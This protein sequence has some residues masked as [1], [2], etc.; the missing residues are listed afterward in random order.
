MSLIKHI[1]LAVVVLTF[2][3]LAWAQNDVPYDTAKDE[4][5]R[6][7]IGIFEEPVR[8]KAR[9]G[10]I[11]SGASWGHSGPCVADVD[12]DG[13]RDLVVG[14]FSGLFR[15]FRNDGSN[16]QPSYVASGNLQAAGADAKVRIY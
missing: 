14:D 6:E 15:F 13:N 1:T 8:L 2:G 10:V 3:H 5:L 16:S 4:P 7:D 12:G 9:D 11:D